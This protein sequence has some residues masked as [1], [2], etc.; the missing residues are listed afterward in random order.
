MQ[1]GS[2]E[3]GGALADGVAEGLVR[4]IKGPMLGAFQSSFQDVV[5]PAF[6]GATTEMLRQMSSAVQVTADQSAAQRASPPS[7]VAEAPVLSPEEELSALLKE[8]R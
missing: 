3:N 5:I 4:D 1:I 2:G 6:E 7:R 8:D